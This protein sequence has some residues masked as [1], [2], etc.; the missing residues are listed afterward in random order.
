ML[1]SQKSSFLL[2]S[3]LALS[4]AAS[5]FYS[6]PITRDM[7]SVP[8]MR[9]ITGKDKARMKSFGTT[10]NLL[11]VVPVINEDVSYIVP[12][13]IGNQSFRLIA[14]T[15]SSNT[16]IGASTPYMPGPASVKDGRFVS[17]TYGSGSFSGSQY[18]DTVLLGNMSVKNQSISVANYSEGFEGTDGILGLGPEKLTQG[19]ITGSQSLIPTVLQTLE[20]QQTIQQNV[21]GVYFQPITGPNMTEANGELSFGGP[22]PSR[23][24]GDITYANITSN[25]LY[26]SYWGI[27][28]DQVSFDGSNSTILIQA[29]SAIVDTGTTLTYLPSPALDAFCTAA[30]GI[31]DRE[32][33]LPV[34]THRPT[35]NLTFTISN[36]RFT[37]SPDQYLV[38]ADQYEIFGLDSTRFYAWLG[39]GGGLGAVNFIIGQKVLEHLYSVYDTTNSRVGLAYALP[40]GSAPQP[41]PQSQSGSGSNSNPGSS[42]SASSA[43]RTVLDSQV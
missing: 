19:T 2:V 16:W 33:T 5:A 43:S 26:S 29:V 6:V 8:K 18:S 13:T 42:A 3:T 4:D 11:G 38:P 40:K 15:G 7:R 21:L 9:N 14:D 32:T 39:D 20:A 24:I 35:S 17:V 30:D 25:S 22:D 34:F 41:Q 27:D 36:T 28:V 10:S 12:V 1:T 37:L 31:I 23:Y